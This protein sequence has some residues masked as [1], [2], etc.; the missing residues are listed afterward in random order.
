MRPAIL[1]KRDGKTFAADGSRQAA[2]YLSK[3]DGRGSCC[4][5]EIDCGYVKEGRDKAWCVSGIKTLR[6]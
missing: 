4:N 2:A 5:N 1:R 6:M 3:A